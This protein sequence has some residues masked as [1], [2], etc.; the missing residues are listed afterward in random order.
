MND[1]YYSHVSVLFNNGVFGCVS[2]F[3]ARISREARDERVIHTHAKCKGMTTPTTDGDVVEIVWHGWIGAKVTCT[4]RLLI[5][6][7]V[8]AVF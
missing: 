7:R 4:A 8:E 1:G 2:T 3:F 5:G 6:L